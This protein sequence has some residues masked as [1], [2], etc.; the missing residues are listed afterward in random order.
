MNNKGQAITFTVIIAIALGL[1]I[2]F[3]GYKIFTS[4]GFMYYLIGGGLMTISIIYGFAGDGFNREKGKYM[5]AFILIGLFIIILPVIGIVQNVAFDPNSY[6]QIPLKGYYKCDVSS[7]KITSA[8]TSVPLGGKTY[9]CPANTDGCLF[10]VSGKPDSTYYKYRYTYQICSGSNCQA[11]VTSD[12]YNGGYYSGKS[13]P[14]AQVSLTNSQSIR[15]NFQRSVLGLFSYS[16]VAG[17]TY[18]IAYNPFIL[19]KI[20]PTGASVRYTTEKQG[21]N[22]K[23]SELLIVSDTLG[24]GPGT[25]TKTSGFA[26]YETRNFIDTFIPANVNIN[27]IQGDK[28]CSEKKLYTIDTITVE[29][30][31][32][33]TRTYN[34]VNTKKGTDVPCCTGDIEP[35]VRQCV[36]NNWIAIPK[37]GVKPKVGDSNCIKCD[38]LFNQ[39]PGND[40]VPYTN[41]QLIRNTCENSCCISKTTTVECTNDAAC[42]GVKSHCDTTI[43]KCVAP[44]IGIIVENNNSI[45]TTDKQACD[46][47][48]IASPFLGY[49]YKESQSSDC[50]FF[51]SIGLGSPVVTTTGYCVASYVPYYI[52]SLAVIL[53]VVIL[54]FLLRKPRRKR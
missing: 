15:I 29:I 38:D 36:D 51:C 46:A 50:G 5:T 21:C 34:I 11:P 17:G 18:Q 41:T 10:T 16:N 47:K 49:I 23:G 33:T 40:N 24:F 35:G 48:A 31:G 27:K 8:V 3:G 13:V 12:E 20:S 28:Y 22:F 26:R 14:A 42:S 37:V 9:K 19:Y 25:T 52:L 45:V 32:S 53:L 4:S 6:I 43:N 54:Y 2:I 44:S 7:E 30:P 1:L 39:C